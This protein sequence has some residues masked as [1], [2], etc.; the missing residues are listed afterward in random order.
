MTT[1]WVGIEPYEFHLASACLLGKLMICHLQVGISVIGTTSFKSH[2]FWR[3]HLQAIFRAS[4]KTLG[5]SD[6]YI[7]T[8]QP[9]CLN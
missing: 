7:D 3:S 2:A 1:Y 5:G 6:N 9:T 8:E 4:W